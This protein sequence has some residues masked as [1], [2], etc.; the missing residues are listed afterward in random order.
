M[1]LAL[2]AKMR[3][4]PQP[5]LLEDIDDFGFLEGSFMDHLTVLRL[6]F[7]AS[8][9]RRADSWWKRLAPQSLGAYLLRQAK[10]H[11]IEQA[12]LHRVIGGFLKN[13]EL[14][15]D[16]G[17]IP[18]ARLPQCLELVGEEEDL[19][20]FLKD[21]RDHLDKV[22]IV[23]LRGEEARYEA[24][25]EREELEQMLDIEQIEQAENSRKSIVD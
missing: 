1:S 11:G 13:Q 19:Q 18:P 20:S 6:Y 25:I 23:F 4:T 22:R 17:E 16:T 12:L 7:S 8:E 24:A 3:A 10:E 15:M 14:L 2:V 5:D 21:N 9:M